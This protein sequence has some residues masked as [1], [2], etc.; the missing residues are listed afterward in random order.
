MA[1][2]VAVRAARLL[3]FDHIV[4]TYRLHTAAAIL[5]CRRTG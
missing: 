5:D 1:V 2:R 4:A 3:C